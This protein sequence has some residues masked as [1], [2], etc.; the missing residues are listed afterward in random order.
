MAT[1]TQT[2][3][4]SAFHPEV[5]SDPLTEKA[6]AKRVKLND[7]LADAQNRRLRQWFAYWLNGDGTTS[8]GRRAWCTT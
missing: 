7:L 6:V 3:T 1:D 2:V 8:A 5:E 4:R